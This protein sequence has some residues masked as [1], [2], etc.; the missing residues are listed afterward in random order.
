M[1]DPMNG[2]AICARESSDDGDFAEAIA[3]AGG[4]LMADTPRALEILLTDSDRETVEAWVRG[5]EAG[6]WN[7]TPATKRFLAIVLR[8]VL[9]AEASRG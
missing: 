2:F 6:K 3:T 4:C 8:R 9:D 1:A 5:I 7:P